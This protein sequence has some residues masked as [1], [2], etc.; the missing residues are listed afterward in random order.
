ML[1]ETSNSKFFWMNTGWKILL[2]NLTVEE[3]QRL[4]LYKSIRKL[5]GNQTPFSKLNQKMLKKIN[6]SKFFWKNV[7]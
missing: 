2:K 3:G 7:R 5:E 1:R 4:I 6:S